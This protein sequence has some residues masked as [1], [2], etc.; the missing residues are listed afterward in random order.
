[1]PPGRSQRGA[2]SRR[3]VLRAA[4]LSAAALPVATGA[5]GCASVSSA[6]LRVAVVWSGAELEAFRAVL[7]PFRRQFHDVQVLSVG[8]DVTA[9]LGSDV[10]RSA[11]ADV[12][13]VSQAGALVTYANRIEE[14]RP[15]AEQGYPRAWQQ[16]V[17][18]PAGRPRGVVFKATL[19]SLVWYQP[20]LF[21]LLGLT[22]PT[23]WE[24]WITVN[25]RLLAAGV[26]PLAIGAA[27]GWVL[28]QW[29]ENTLI[30]ESTDVYDR[31]AAPPGSAQRAGVTWRD[32][33]VTRSL[34]RLGTMWSPPGALAGGAR[35]ALSTQFTDSVLDVFRRDRAAMV[36]GAD[37][38]YPILVRYAA[39][40]ASP[41]W[42]RFPAPARAHG[43]PAVVGG[44]IAVLLRPARPVG[45]ELIGW[46][47]SAQAQRIWAGRGGY[48]SVRDGVEP[49]AYPGDWGLY[50]QPVLDAVRTPADGT[51][52][53]S[54]AAQLGGALQSG[55]GTG[56]WQVLQD[57]FGQVGGGGGVAS[58]V[59]QAVATLDRLDR[60]ER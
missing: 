31:L 20:R 55:P 52:H 5:A 7:N 22:P 37:Y 39:A 48:I 11:E 18:D 26:A 14:L 50:Q 58:A 59:D 36:V 49:D 35:R 60:S 28:S 24:A 46:L 17:R 16:V 33:A 4:A 32:P 57:F 21:D 53:F 12:V 6:A 41:R 40:D 2:V 44:D 29:F 30:G 23:T 38:V 8:D 47:A 27:D 3:A 25:Q 43:A 51:V 19:T 56:L 34:W 45:H 9:L 54:L 15:D 1:M 42:F 13:M 10:A